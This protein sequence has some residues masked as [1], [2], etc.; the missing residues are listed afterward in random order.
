MACLSEA[1]TPKIG[2]KFCACVGWRRLL[3]NSV[4]Q[5]RDSACQCR[6][7][8]LE[9]GAGWA[10]SGLRSVAHAHDTYGV[11]TPSCCVSTLIHGWLDPRGHPRLAT[12]F[13]TRSWFAASDGW[14]RL[15]RKVTRWSPG[16]VRSRT[17]TDA[18]RR[19]PTLTDADSRCGAFAPSACD[20]ANPYPSVTGPLSIAFLQRL[21]HTTLLA[22][23]YLVHLHQQNYC[24]EKYQYHHKFYR[25][26]TTR[27][28]CSTL[29]YCLVFLCNMHT[30]FQD[31]WVTWSIDMGIDIVFFYL[32]VLDK[33]N[34]TSST[35]YSKGG[36]C[37]FT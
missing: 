24:Y 11:C 34:T 2:I 12:N 37:I 27:L 22:A 21:C 4:E 5:R 6:G 20:R 3:Y 26:Q 32:Y 29:K 30:V 7:S 8:V 28:I 23:L 16:N 25:N 35:S 18:Y 15:P 19:L 33:W 1:A 31:Y 36:I 13:W 17:L 10:I 9:K 14:T